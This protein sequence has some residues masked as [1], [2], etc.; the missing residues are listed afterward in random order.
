MNLPSAYFSVTPKGDSVVLSGRGFGHGVGLC[1]EGAMK[2]A[3]MGY[4]FRQI[5]NYYY[6][7]VFISDINKAAVVPQL[8]TMPESAGKVQLNKNKEAVVALKSEG[9]IIPGSK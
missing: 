9:M 5:I 6:S 4:S 7:G 2:M 3:G 8:L 1:Q